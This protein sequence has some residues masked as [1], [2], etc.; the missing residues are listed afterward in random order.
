MILRPYRI[1]PITY[2]WAGKIDVS[3]PTHLMQRVNRADRASS[4]V[5]TA[6]GGWDG[7]NVKSVADAARRRRA[8]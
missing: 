2:Q 1:D 3:Q 6:F 8:Y 7:Q 4:A 5:E